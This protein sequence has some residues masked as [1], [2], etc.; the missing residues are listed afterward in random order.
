MILGKQRQNVVGVEAVKVI[1]KDGALRH[2]LPV[3]LAPKRFAPAGVR[4]GQVQTVALDAVPIFCRDVM[5][6]GVFVAV[7][8]NFGI[9]RCAGGEEHG[10][11]ILAAGRVG[12]ALE[13]SGIEGVLFIEAVPA[14][15]LSAD[16]DL[17]FQLGAGLGGFVNGV[18]DR[19]VRRCDDGA[20]ACGLEAVFKVMCKELIGCG[21]GN[22]TELVQGEHGEPKLVM[23]LKHQHYAV[24]LLDAEGAEIVRRLIG[25]AFDVAESEA[26]FDLVSIQMK[27]GKLIGIGVCQ[28][29]HG[30]KGKVIAVFVLKCDLLQLALVVLGAFDKFFTQQMLARARNSDALTD[31]LRLHVLARQDNGAE[32]TVL[33]V[34]GNHAV[35][36]GAVIVDGVTWPENL[37]VIANLHLELAADD[38]VK[39]LTGVGACMNREI[40]LFGAIAVADKVRLCDFM[41]K[42]GSEI[43]DLDAAL[44]YHNLSL[45]AAS[46]SVGRE[47]R[48]PTLQDRRR[49]NAEGDGAFMQ[50]GEREVAGA[51]FI[52]GILLDGRVGLFC[53]LLNGE[54]RNL[55]H[56]ANTFCNGG[57]GGIVCRCV[58]R[59]TLF[60]C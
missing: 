45:A 39:F 3:E 43:A 22:C 54:A 29:I 40:L 46:D 58:H 17:G 51:V 53:H 21:N 8:G 28:S 33:A 42:A 32:H 26:A 57:D 2:P 41:A 38:I 27:H 20:D 6:E 15:A 34:Y 11:D 9:A 31:G 47:L 50:E 12:S 4:N 13:F 49:L 35:R 52:S 14:L 25:G 37:G 10:A 60:F 16:Q 23:P 56:I 59:Q 18:R 44:L 1:G 30:V 5:P 7:R 24:A 19:A 55:A 36:C 48:C